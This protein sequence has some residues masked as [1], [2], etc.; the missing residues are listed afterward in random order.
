MEDPEEN[1]VAALSKVLPKPLFQVP[2]NPT[3]KKEILPYLILREALTVKAKVG[4]GGRTSN[5]EPAAP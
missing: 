2:P 1:F 4:Y 5:L 3:C